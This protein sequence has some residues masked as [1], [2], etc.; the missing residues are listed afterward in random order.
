MYVLHRK[1][2]RE[3]RYP[4]KHVLV[5]KKDFVATVTLNNPPMNL[6]SVE[7]MGALLETFRLL[8]FDPEARVVVVT[9]AGTRAFNVGSNLKEMPGMTGHFRDRKFNLESDLMATI[10][11]LP[12]PTICAIEG[13]CMG[14]GL[15]LACCFDLRVASEKAVFST[16]EINVGQ[17]PGS[18]GLF[19]L[20]KLIGPSRTL[21]MI[22]TG[23]NVD[24]QEA[25]QMGLVNRLCEPGTARSAAF[26]LAKLIASKPPKPMR[27]SKQFVRENAYKPNSDCIRK[28]MDYIED[29]YEDYNA[30]EGIHA[31]LEKRPPRFILN[32]EEEPLNG[33]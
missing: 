3:F 8:R 1:V 31:F 26:E 29:L 22:Y 32:E 2:P 20:P 13:Y 24:A 16:P 9:G 17:L 15:E 5:E 19:R 18:G 33:E 11:E 23:R 21:D 7:S 25:Y 12:K 6:N 28:N 4:D 14:G 30:M 10:D 27:I